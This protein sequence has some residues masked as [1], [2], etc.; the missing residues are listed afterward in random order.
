MVPWSQV[1]V[2]HKE[3][4]V[5]RGLLFWLWIIIALGSI[6]LLSRGFDRQAAYPAMAIRYLPIGMKGVFIAS[7]FAAL[8][9]SIDSNINTQ[10]S[11]MVNDLYKNYLVKNASDKHYVFVSRIATVFA[12]SVA[13]IIWRT[14]LSGTSILKNFKLISMLMAGGAFINFLQWFWWRINA[15]AMAA[16]I[17]ASMIITTLLK[18]V[19]PAHVEWFATYNFATK[20]WAFGMLITT[21]L[22]TLI[23]LLVALLTKPTDME[24]LKEFYRRFQP[25]GFWG[26][27]KKIVGSAV[28]HDKFSKSDI[29][30]W[31][32][33]VFGIYCLIFGLGKLLLGSY[34]LGGLL[35]A[36]GLIAIKV[37]LWNIGKRE[38]WHKKDPQSEKL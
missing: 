21:L 8:M 36:L 24:K 18:F 3:N 4:I 31:A 35:L 13:F 32:S 14:L 17:L 6:V 23:G 27:V 16:G 9:S 33:V 29:L 34:L 30:T 15:A 1:V 38:W 11:W 20:Y 37:M 12:L 28:K 2:I 19:L 7:V 5:E 25:I 26:P 10:A 22:S